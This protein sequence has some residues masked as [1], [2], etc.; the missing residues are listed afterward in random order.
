MAGTMSF[1]MRIE[2]MHFRPKANGGIRKA[3]SSTYGFYA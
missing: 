2:T 3:G 1:N